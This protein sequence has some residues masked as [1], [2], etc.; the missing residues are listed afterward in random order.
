MAFRRG[1]TVATL[2]LKGGVGH[3]HGTVGWGRVRERELERDQE[4][5]PGLAGPKPRGSKTDDQSWLI[6]SIHPSTR[7]RLKAAQHKAN[8][9]PHRKGPGRLVGKNMCPSPLTLIIAKIGICSAI[10]AMSYR[11]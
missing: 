10:I 3:A 1:L 11:A 4:K 5:P 9:R 6:L 7:E 2:T 8:N